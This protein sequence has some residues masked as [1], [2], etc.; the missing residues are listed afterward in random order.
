V[1]AQFNLGTMYD[2][3]QGVTQSYTEAVRWY[4]KA[5][6]QGSKYAQEYLLRT[7]AAPNLERNRHRE[8]STAVERNRHLA[9]QGCKNA[10]YCMGLAY[11]KGDGVPVDESVA[12]KWWCPP[13]QDAAARLNFT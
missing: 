11:Y 2:V 7:A 8:K 9:E 6:E 13:L 5:A 12:L 4:R 1:L 10:M 3:G